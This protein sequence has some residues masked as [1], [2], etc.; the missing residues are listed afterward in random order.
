MPE[1]PDVETFRRYVT[2][3]SLHQEIA[4]VEVSNTRVLAGT[5]PSRFKQALKGRTFTSTGRRG[6]HLFVITD[7]AR[8]LV[9]H[10]GMTGYP[11]YRKAQTSG[12]HDR[13]TFIF[14]GGASLAFVC[15]RLFGRLALTRSVEAYVAKKR[16]GP[17]AMDISADDLALRLRR[18]K[19]GIKASLMNQRLI[20]GLG[21]LYCDEILFQSGVHP[22]LTGDR[23]GPEPARRI[24]RNM[25]K[26]LR[27]ATRRNAD[28]MRLPRSYLLPHRR[29]GGLC[30]Q[31]K[32][33][34][35]RQTVA[36]RTTYW[37]PA[38]QAR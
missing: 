32:G 20:A 15:P 8:C 16:L 22:Q 9:L 37:C 17:D 12:P 6:K 3:T 27:M 36:G 5:S 7:N 34:L 33:L 4:D 19:A 38:C 10:F 11:R 31:C 18:S 13:V 28:P 26:V 24:H 2:A 14:A 21:N 23:L 1:W 29:P 35:A 25:R 30:P